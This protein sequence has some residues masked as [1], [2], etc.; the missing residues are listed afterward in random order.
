MIETAAETIRVDTPA[1]RLIGE[2]HGDILSFKGIPFARPPVGPLRWR[3]A[4]PLEPWAG[5]RDATRFGPVCPQAPTQLEMLIGSTLGEQAEDCLYLNIWTPGC[6]GARRP[7]MVWIHGGAFMIGAGSQ[8][9]YSGEALA[10]RGVVVVTVNYRLGAFGFVDLREASGGAL[11]ASGTEGLSDQLLALHWV[12]R[13]ITRFGGDPAN[14]T[15]FGESA[16]GMSVCALLA[17]P[18]ARGLFHKAIAQS[19]GA[20]IGH[21]P[22]RAARVGG[23][24]LSALKLGKDE[25]AKAHEL[26][27]G[28][29][30]GAQIAVQADAREG[31]DGQKLGALPFQPTLDG[32]ILDGPPI[33]AIR[34][35]SAAGVPLLT[36]TTAEEWKLFSAPNPA[37]RLM[38]A[39]NLAQR[40][41]RLAGEAAPE[42]AA[43]YEEGSV[44]ERF[45]A[46]MTDKVFTQPC[47]RLLEAQDAR[48]PVYT[49]RFDW[50]SKLLGGIMGSCHGLDVGFV[51]GSYRERLAGAFFGTGPEADA[52][53]ETMMEAWVAFAHTGNPATEK[54]GPWPRY[55]MATRSTLIFGDGAPHLV[56]A[57]NE[58]RRKA[59]LAVPERR[60]G[61]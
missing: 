2:R 49:Y 15:A 30:V 26:P 14:V 43:V 20:H 16:G 59:W 55:D 31:K 39:K 50:R 33:A 56:N 28:A 9:I 53:S 23:A 51:F 29:V 18:A 19:G 44:F 36:G 24:V 54:T 38:S 6:D 17:A 46:L 11:P 12:K 7:V 32:R 10:A 35:G 8:G 52:L 27:Y 61:P 3:M 47:I 40:I 45:N 34:S 5:V 4:E 1:G 60:L 21:T 37:T 57:P 48:A 13:N 25:A 58:A 41:E 22:E 42:M